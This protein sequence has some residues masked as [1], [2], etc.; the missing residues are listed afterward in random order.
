MTTVHTVRAVLG[1]STKK[2]SVL[3]AGT[4]N[5][6][7]KMS[8]DQQQFPNPIPSMP[9]YLGLITA[10]EASQPAVNSR[11]KGASTIRNNAATALTSGTKQLL[12]GVQILADTSPEN[13]AAIVLASG[14]KV[15][16]VRP[17]LLSPVMLTNA[18]PVGTVT[19]RAYVA[20]LTGNTHKSVS[21]SWQYSID[22]EKTWINLP[23]TPLSRTTITGLAPMTVVAARVAVTVGKLPI[24]DWS[25]PGTLTVV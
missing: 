17:H 4:R 9:T 25:A 1:F 21:Y 22:G 3:N 10:L 24:T 19:V 23:V 13:A 6:Y 8:V 7:S 11:T 15:A 16:A 5:I 12:T 2:I 20:L 18:K 14:F